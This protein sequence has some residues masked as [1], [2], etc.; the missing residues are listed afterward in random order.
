MVDFPLVVSYERPFN[1]MNTDKLQVEDLA[2][3]MDLYST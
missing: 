3:E 1:F 2:V